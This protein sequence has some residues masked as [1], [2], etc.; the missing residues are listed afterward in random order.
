MKLVTLL[1]LALLGAGTTAGPAAAQSQYKCLNADGS[2]WWSSK[3]CPVPSPHGNALRKCIGR[4]GAVS[5]QQEPCGAGARQVS[6]REV[7]PEPPPTP[8]QIRA[9]E[10]KAQQDRAE[11]AYLSRAAGT[12]GRRSSGGRMRTVASVS[13]PSECELARKHR[14]DVLAAVGMKRTYDLLRQLNDK[15]H[16]AC[17]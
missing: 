17:R 7:H 5:F 15:V 13:P 11:S 2:V 9:R 8:E 3:A 16:A 6:I 14:D 10:L 12:D 4:S 1:A